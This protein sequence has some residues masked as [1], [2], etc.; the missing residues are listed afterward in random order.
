M[1]AALGF[2]DRVELWAGSPEPERC[3]GTVWGRP[4]LDENSLAVDRAG[5]TTMVMWDG[6]SWSPNGN[7]WGIELTESLTKI[8]TAG[9]VPR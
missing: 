5:L 9:R 1:S 7:R 4:S 2:M 3:V 8:G 6:P